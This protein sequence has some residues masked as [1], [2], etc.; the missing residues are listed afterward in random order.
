MVLP[1]FS[2]LPGVLSTLPCVLYAICAFLSLYFPSLLSLSFSPFLPRLYSGYW[3]GAQP[4]IRVLPPLDQPL[5]QKGSSLPSSRF[6]LPLPCHFSFL[7]RTEHTAA[8]LHT[9]GI[10]TPFR[11]PLSGF[12][13]RF[14]RLTPSPAP[15]LRLCPVSAPSASHPQQRHTRRARR[16][17]R[18]ALPLPPLSSTP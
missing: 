9:H 15:P 2:T 13:S 14:A 6:S 3:L 16:H 8:T 11:I 7:T 5:V 1:P 18:A 10:G 4:L 12:G 17:S